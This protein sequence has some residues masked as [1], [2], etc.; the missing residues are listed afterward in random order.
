MALALAIAGDGCA[1]VLNVQDAAMRK[2]YGGFTMP[3]NDFCGGEP[4]GEYAALVCW[5]LWLADKPLSLFGDTIALPYLLWL[6]RDAR[7]PP[8]GQSAEPVQSP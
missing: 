4:G 5:P 7:P 2:P 6:Q 1:T 3:L 8:N